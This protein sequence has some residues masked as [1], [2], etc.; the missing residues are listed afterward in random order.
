VVA[1]VGVLMAKIEAIWS[2]YKQSSRLY[3][4]ICY[5]LFSPYDIAYLIF[6]AFLFALNTF[7]GLLYKLGI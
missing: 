3:I 7:L 5:L 1:V 6:L 2:L 4:F